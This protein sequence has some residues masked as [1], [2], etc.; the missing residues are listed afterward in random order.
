MRRPLER[1]AGKQM[2][3]DKLQPARR[4]AT[5]TKLPTRAAAGAGK[6][7][8]EK[9]APQLKSS[10]PPPKPQ[11]RAERDA[12]IRRANLDRRLILA[13]NDRKIDVRIEVI[14]ESLKDLLG[15]RRQVRSAIE[16]TGIPLALYDEAKADALKTRVDLDE[17][18]RLRAEARE[19]FSVPTGVAKD[20]FDGVPDAAKEAVHWDDMGY[21]A[22]R[23]G[24]DRDL[25]D[26][27]PPECE[28]DF[29]KAWERAQLELAGA[30]KRTDAATTG[31]MTLEDAASAG[32]QGAEDPNASH[33]SNGTAAASDAEADA[34]VQEVA[35]EV[36]A[37][38][39]D[40]AVIRPGEDDGF[41]MSPAELEQQ[42]A[43]R[44]VQDGRETDEVLAPHGTAAQRERLNP[45]E[46]L[47]DA[48][49]TYGTA[50]LASAKT[51]GG[52]V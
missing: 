48:L 39:G 41:E 23:A 36:A 9:P 37:E 8:P 35:A 34:I 18:E 47:S 49:K 50:D 5:V 10:A 2:M 16:G 1:R 42:A 22:G 3:A 46:E 20:L 19:I 31:G 12:Q 32:K 26:G 14:R 21:R 27:I 38:A 40:D 29:L 51:S 43:R 30:V 28:Q 7:R 24:L 15:E 52:I 25:P 4:S 11:T 33:V 6:S 17:K 45:T 13:A 44:A